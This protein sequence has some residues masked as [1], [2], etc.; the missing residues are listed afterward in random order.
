MSKIFHV[1]FYFYLS[2]KPILLMGFLFRKKERLLS[3]IQKHSQDHLLPFFLSDYSG[4]CSCFLAC[5]TLFSLYIFLHILRRAFVLPKTLFLPRLEMAGCLVSQYFLHF[6]I[7]ELIAN[8]TFYCPTARGL[9]GLLDILLFYPLKIREALNRLTHHNAHT[10]LDDFSINI[11][12]LLRNLHRL[13]MH[14]IRV[15][16]ESI[17]CKIL[18]AGLKY[19]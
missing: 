5:S 9:C 18:P 16:N 6:A 10:R 19:V 11:S 1:F 12:K 13:R 2:S 15:L 14:N 3:L 7:Q 17:S 8:C 4:A